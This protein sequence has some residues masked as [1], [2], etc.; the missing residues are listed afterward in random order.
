MERVVFHVNWPAGVTE[1]HFVICTPEEWADGPEAE[2]PG[3]AV[4]RGDNGLVYAAKLVGP[5]ADRCAAPPA[6]D[7]AR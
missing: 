3:W 1:K 7:G 6:G 4:M 5:G 2:D